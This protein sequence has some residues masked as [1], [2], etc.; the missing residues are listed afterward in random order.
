ML[1]KLTSWLD[2]QI[3]E[4]LAKA[5]TEL[6][7]GRSKDVAAEVRQRALPLLQIKS[8]ISCLDSR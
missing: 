6:E 1:V 5:L 7:A 3:D 4:D 2:E 8:V